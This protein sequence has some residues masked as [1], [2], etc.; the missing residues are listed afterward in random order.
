MRGLDIEMNWSNVSINIKDVIQLIL[1]VVGGTLAFSA[2][3]SKMD[4]QNDKLDVFIEVVKEMK[5]DSKE[6]KSEDKVGMQQL[7][8][9]V[10]TNSIQI[11]II[12]QRVLNMESKK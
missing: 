4:K 3:S 1:I 9:Q 10:N 8:N 11:K 12:E 6:A 7:I 5:A 2:Q